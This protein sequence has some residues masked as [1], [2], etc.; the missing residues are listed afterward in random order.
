MYCFE[1][2]TSSPSLITSDHLRKCPAYA[3]SFNKGGVGLSLAGFLE[4]DE[5]KLSTREI[6]IQEI[7]ELMSIP[8]GK[9]IASEE[10]WRVNFVEFV[11]GVSCTTYF[12]VVKGTKRV[13]YI[14]QTEDPDARAVK[15]LKATNDRYYIIKLQDGVPKKLARFTELFAQSLFGELSLLAARDVLDFTCSLF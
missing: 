6:C 4:E 14:G 5:E 9:V 13:E 2:T 15:N 12:D 1:Y 11:G 3:S 8:S 10:G 7:Y